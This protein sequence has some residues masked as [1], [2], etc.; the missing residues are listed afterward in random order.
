[1][2]AS[3]LVMRSTVLCC[4]ALTFWVAKISPHQVKH[5]KP[6]FV[7]SSPPAVALANLLSRWDQLLLQLV[8]HIEAMII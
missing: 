4:F 3:A 7:Q 8:G 2:G 6:H 1:M 5:L